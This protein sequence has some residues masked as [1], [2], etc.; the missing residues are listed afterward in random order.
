MGMRSE[1]AAMTTDDLCEHGFLHLRRPSSH[2]MECG[3]SIGYLETVLLGAATTLS[4][5]SEV[6]TS[7]LD[8]RIHFDPICCPHNE[9]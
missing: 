5:H 6:Y 9:G 3:K 1:S 2:L 7:F 8:A 4:V